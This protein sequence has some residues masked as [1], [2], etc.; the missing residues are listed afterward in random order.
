MWAPG[1]DGTPFSRLFAYEIQSKDDQSLTSAL[2]S[3]H[4][5]EHG[6]ALAT[7]H[8]HAIVCGRCGA[9]AIAEAL[10]DGVLS[11]PLDAHEEWKGWQRSGAGRRDV[12]GGTWKTV[13]P[14][15]HKHPALR[16]LLDV[17]PAVVE[18]P[19]CQARNLIDPR[20]L[21]LRAVQTL[22]SG[23]GSAEDSLLPWARRPG[24]RTLR[25]SGRPGAATPAR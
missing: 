20:S 2:D 22:A 7:R 17:L 18:C 25:S 9:T 13:H 6:L 21:R 24:S 14:A 1:Q 4:L 23:F 5:G 16:G 12:P 3:A 10:A 8:G 19:G 15:S 11:F